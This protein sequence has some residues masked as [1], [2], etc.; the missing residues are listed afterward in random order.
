MMHNRKDGFELSLR[1]YQRIEA[2]ATTVNTSDR[3]NRCFVGR[4]SQ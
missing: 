1:T 2:F 4:A 3:S